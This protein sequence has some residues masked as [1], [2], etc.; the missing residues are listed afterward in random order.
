MN[1]FH[2]FSWLLVCF[3]LIMMVG[4]EVQLWISASCVFVANAVCFTKFCCG[5]TLAHSQGGCTALIRAAGGKTEC[6]RVLLDAG[7]DKE[8]KDKVP[9]QI[10]SSSCLR[11]FFAF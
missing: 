7:A 1:F 3:S 6:V 5:C 4:L 9:C 10:A 8:A 2:T 11:M